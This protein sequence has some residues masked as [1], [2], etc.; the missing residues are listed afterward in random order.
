MVLQS[1]SH[2]LLKKFIGGKKAKNKK[3]FCYIRTS[4]WFLFFF[5]SPGWLHTQINNWGKSRKTEKI[6]KTNVQISTYNQHRAEKRNNKKTALCFT[7][8]CTQKEWN[9]GMS[10]VKKGNNWAVSQQQTS[11]C[12]FLAVSE[13]S[14]HKWSIFEGQWKPKASQL[15]HKNINWD[16]MKSCVVVQVRTGHGLR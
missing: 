6:D 8:N 10:T 4:N 13:H 5:G 14:N 1:F 16:A 15:Y 2:N 11:F 7:K 9:C 12:I 3:L